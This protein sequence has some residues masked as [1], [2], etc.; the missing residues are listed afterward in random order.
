MADNINVLN[1]VVRLVLV[2]YAGLIASNLP[3]NVA[4]LFGNIAVRFLCVLLILG[5]SLYDATAAILLAVGFVVSIQTAN[6]YHISK[7]ANNAITNSADA[8]PL[9]QQTQQQPA[10]DDT[11]AVFDIDDDDGD[12]AVD[13]IEAF[14]NHSPPPISLSPPAASASEFTSNMQFG[15][16]QSNLVQ[17]NQQTE[18][19]T[20]QNEMGP[21]G[22]SQPGGYSN[23]GCCKSTWLAAYDDPAQTCV[24]ASK[25]QQQQ[26]QQQ[27]LQQQ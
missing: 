7:L 9:V 20:W 13:D 18:V 10:T 22:L 5:L 8:L 24:S 1:S 26:Q 15:I 14:T 19:R 27:Q 2:L 4:E 21:Q 25:Q 3:E 12:A 23:T 6:K 16:A 17:D 11:R